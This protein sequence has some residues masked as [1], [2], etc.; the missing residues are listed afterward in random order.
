MFGRVVT[1]FRSD[2]FAD[3]QAVGWK[4]LALAWGGS[5]LPA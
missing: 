5:I 3:D 2:D 1:G 4:V